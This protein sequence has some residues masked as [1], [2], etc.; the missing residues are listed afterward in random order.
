MA[1]AN[2]SNDRYAILAEKWLNGTITPGEEKEYA[3]WYNSLSADDKVEVPFEWAADREE[4]RKKLL[5][6]IMEKR[7]RIVPLRT[8]VLRGVAAAAA[9]LIVVLGAYKLV[10]NK[11]V[12]NPVAATPV[13]TP[14]NDIQPGS[15]G[16]MLT[17]ANGNVIVLDTAKNGRLLND[18][19]N[20]VMKINGTISFA[21]AANRAPGT[22]GYNTLST[23]RARQQQLILSDGTVIWMNAESSVKFPTAFNGRTR[24]IDV[25]GEVYCEVAKDASKPFIVHVND[26]AVQ[27]LGT[28]FNIM[29]YTN[30]PSLQTTLLEGSVKFIKGRNEL[31]LKPGQQ[32]QLFPGDR[33][34][35]IPDA[36][37]ESATA[38]KNGR[39]V[40]NGA[41]IETLM[42]SL[43][44][45]YDI[46]VE[47]KG[48][49]PHR[50]FTGDIPRTANLSEIVTLL[51]VNKIKAT[52]NAANKRLVLE[53]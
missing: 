52:L 12:P 29:A 37:T 48:P 38:W 42:R 51:E 49:M 15:N 6:L 30:E 47:Y 22:I 39:Q 5:A 28:H 31:L 3:D 41:D 24:E 10:Q 20:N 21:H 7:G 9:I 44:R 36:D 4:H 23:P 27:V 53:P 32:S 14:V 1:A 34:K 18:A 2:N 11:P 16:A 35:F 46:T 8:K 26:A 40:F 43:E 25:T 17:L 45:W 19:G 33:L 50:T 13:K